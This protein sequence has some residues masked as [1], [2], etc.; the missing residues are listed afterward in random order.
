MNF[1]E[2]FNPNARI[3]VNSSLVKLPTR[4]FKSQE[5]FARHVTIRIRL[6][7][8]RCFFEG[9][10]FRFPRSRLGHPEHSRVKLTTFAWQA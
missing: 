3:S 10:L 4:V 7:I 1:S 8:K 6:A 5:L 2:N 9:F